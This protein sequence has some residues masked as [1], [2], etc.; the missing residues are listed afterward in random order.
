MIDVQHSLFTLDNNTF[1][2]YIDIQNY[3]Y[4]YIYVYCNIHTHKSDCDKSIIVFLRKEI[5]KYSNNNRKM[6]FYFKNIQAGI[7][8]EEEDNFD[9]D[10]LEQ[11]LRRKN[12][13]IQKD[14]EEDESEED[15]EMKTL[16][17]GSLKSAESQIIEEE[18]LERKKNKKS[19][20][21][22][23]QN[24]INSYKKEDEKLKAKTFKE[25]Q[26]DDDSDDSDG[27]LFEEEDDDEY[28]N[29]NKNRKKKKNKHAPSELSSKKKT[30]YLRDI[31]GLPSL[32]QQ[33]KRE[34]IRFDKSLGGHPSN[35]AELNVIRSR[36][37]FLDEYRQKEIDE[38]EM[39]LNDKKLVNKMDSNDR[40]ELESTLRSL[41]SRLETVKQKDMERKIVKD[42]EDEINKNNTN[43]KF[44]LKKADKRKVINKWKFE[45]MKA[46]QREKVMQ[47]KRKKQLGKEYRQF[48]FHR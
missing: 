5:K 4:I 9:Q 44:Y 15:D 17:F 41:K 23:K 1:V 3:I 38:M 11:I 37:K 43:N 18:A 29:N 7:D 34:D 28:N 8:S 24:K 45:H 14:E 2:V 40:E 39:T 22:E 25:E 35:Q 46:N 26:F 27:G 10:E 31:P 12:R 19:K 48:T 6:S 47:R 16:S 33:E 21:L 36:Y 13:N 32:R 42:Y 20:K 30:S